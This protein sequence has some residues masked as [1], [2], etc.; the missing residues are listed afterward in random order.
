MIE[1]SGLTKTFH[2]H[3]VLDD[4]NLSIHARER[5][6]LI[7]QNGAGKTTLI[8][9]L[10]GQYRYEGK[11][12][13]WTQEPQKNREALLQKI[14]F[15]PQHPPPLPMNVGE[16]VQFSASI[17]TQTTLE[18]IYQVADELGL[19]LRQ[20][21]GKPFMKLSGGMKQKL[22]IALAL[23]KNPELLIMD[24]PAANLDPQGRKAFFLR[25][26]QIPLE[27]TMM[28]SSHRVDELLSLVNRVIE[29]DCGR[30][31][32]DEPLGG[33]NSS[34]HL[35]KCRMVM[36]DR[37]DFIQKIINEWKFE[38]TQPLVFEG[39]I[40]AVDRMRFLNAVSQF[41]SHIHQLTMAQEEL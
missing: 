18:R 39:H 6:A 36:T 1:I 14:G 29:M 41:A 23:A 30:I 31:V 19:D 8:R 2:K 13:A 15:V 10:M 3:K 22:L 28:L 25:L 11:V 37:N 33:K 4:V 35:L 20:H 38:E 12:E 5:I 27:T 17:C 9:C 24:E 34:V 40:V 7:G 21:L 32:L 16:L 26:A